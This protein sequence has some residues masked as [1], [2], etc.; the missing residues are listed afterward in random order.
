MHPTTGSGPTSL[1][2]ATS[3]SPTTFLDT[4]RGLGFTEQDPHPDAVHTTVRHGDGDRVVL[5]HCHPDDF[6][7]P[8]DDG[9]CHLE[10][11][12]ST[13]AATATCGRAPSATSTRCR[14][15][16]PCCAPPPASTT[17][18]AAAGPTRRP[19]SPKGRKGSKPRRHPPR[20]PAS[21]PPRFGVGRADPL[22]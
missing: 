2:P 22:V 21:C 5:V 3:A 4:L 19:P 13:R 9:D 12:A 16:S 6:A 8:S 11:S 14:S 1:Q 17:N 15:R 18:A 7:E 10:A 20:P